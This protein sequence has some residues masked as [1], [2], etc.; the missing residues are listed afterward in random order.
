MRAGVI[1]LIMMCLVGCQNN[2]PQVFEGY[3]MTM[4]YKVII[5]DP[6]NQ[7]QV[8]KIISDT[9]ADTDNIFNK[10]NKDSELSRLNRLE[11]GTKVPLSPLL[12][13]LFIETDAIVSFSGGRFDPTIEPLQTL[14]KAAFANRTIP[15][16]QDI[17]A[18]APA[19]G[20]Q[21]IH[22][23]NGIFFKDHSGTQ[24]DFGGIAKGLCIDLIAERLLE[25][26][27]SN[28]Y[29]EWGGEIR[30]HGT[31]PEGRPWTI[32]ISRLDDSSPDHAI[33][34]IPLADQAIATSG[35][36]LQNWK[37]KDSAYFHIFDPA[38]LKPLR[39]GTDSI[40]SA[41]VLAK[42]CAFADGLATVA[43]MFSSAEQAEA[44]LNLIAERYPEVQFWIISRNNN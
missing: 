9:F 5:G 14:W 10:W 21:H 37:V 15:T 4:A 30:T 33:A 20:W 42:T 43:M 41:S 27:F 38:T 6:L 3:A 26:G 40:A 24:L 7:K 23:E 19:I 2:T 28:F 32:F 39:Q 29:V 1:F 25:H 17:A 16:E 8:E 13:R 35:D 36:Y 11:A 34:T 18:I 12:E 31:H 44:W 22:F